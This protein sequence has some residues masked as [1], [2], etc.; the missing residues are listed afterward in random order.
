MCDLCKEVSCLKKLFL[1]ALLVGIVSFSYIDVF[2]STGN[3]PVPNLQ[4]TGGIS[5]E[6]PDL[7]VTFDTYRT[8][9]GI[10]DEGTTINIRVLNNIDG[11]LVES[12]TIKDVV[13]VSG[14]FSYDLPLQVAD[15]IIR[16]EATK[17]NMESITITTIRRIGLEIKHEI[18]G[19][20]IA[21]PGRNIV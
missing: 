18:E 7:Q 2:A 12:F 21:L 16:V 1:A 11:K 15:N 10:S 6:N 19:Q 8:I 4:I 9:T 13:G 14:L 5:E 20:S 17:D 3:K